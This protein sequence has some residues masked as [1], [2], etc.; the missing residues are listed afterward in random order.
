MQGYGNVGS[1]AARIAAKSG[2]RVVA[3]SDVKGGV[4]DPR[5]L[6]FAE[7]DAWVA[8]H[9]YLEG[10]PGAERVTNEELLELDCEVLVPAALQNQL[11]D[12]NAGGVRA[13]VV[14]EGANGPTTLEADAILRDRG[15][16][17]VPDVLANSGGV[18]V[19]YF[20]WVQDAQQLFWS[21][22]EVNER[23][24]KI[25]SAAFRATLDFAQAKQLD[26]RTASLWR[27]IE[28]VAEAK[29]RRGVF[30]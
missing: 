1:N 24:H 23:L 19:S 17:V 13:R 9:R 29:R 12:K 16:F 5:G 22:E 25:Q 30:P 6:D 26:M 15:V 8:E 2:A 7:L 10:Y 21:E 18:T 11:T 20:E 3:V 27:G 28:R 14:V 4:Y